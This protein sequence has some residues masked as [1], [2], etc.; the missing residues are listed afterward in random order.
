MYIKLNQGWAGVKNSKAGDVVRCGGS[1]GPMLLEMGFGVEVPK[2]RA[3]NDPPEK[4]AEKPVVAKNAT[5]KIETADSNPTDK[6]ETETA[7]V[8]PKK[9][10]KKGAKKKVDE[11]SILSKQSKDPYD[12]ARNK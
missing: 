9:G 8:T 3:V 4:P 5:V 12:A 7:E 10:N 11:A 2:Q 6:P 1:K